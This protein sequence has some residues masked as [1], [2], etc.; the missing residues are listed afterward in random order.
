M[1]GQVPTM[2]RETQ[3]QGNGGADQALARAAVRMVPLSAYLQRLVWW[4]MLPLLAV[5]LYLGVDSV[6]ALRAANNRAA[7]QLASEIARDLEQFLQARMDALD[8]LAH[9]PSLDA[10]RQPGAFQRAAQPL[11]RSF[12]S[13][14]ILADAS[15]QMLMHTGQAHGSPLPR[16]PQPAGQSALQRALA[17]GRPAAG[18]SFTGPLTGLRMVGVAVPLAGAGPGV[19]PGEVLLISID[20]RQ[21]QRLIDGVPLPE[22]WSVRVVDSQQQALAERPAPGA[23]SPPARADTSQQ[24]TLGSTLAPWSITL[25]SS[26]QAQAAPVW[27]A[28]RVLGLAIVGATL[29]GWLAGGLASRRLARAVASLSGDSPEAA[30][31]EPIREIA[32]A[33]KRL[34]DAQRQR[35][36]SDAATRASEAVFRAVFLGLPDAAVLSDSA[37]RIQLVNPAFEAQFGMPAATVLGRSTDCLHA[38]EAGRA[39]IGQRL[40]DPGTQAGLDVCEMLYR[41]QDGSSFWAETSLVRLHNADGSLRGIFGLHRDISQRR[42]ARLGAQRERED[43]AQQVSA[44]TAELELAFRALEDTARFNRAVT[45]N[46][47]GRVTYWDSGLVCRFANQAQLAWRGLP[48]DQ[49]LGRHMAEL[50]DADS[51]A[52]ALPHAQAALGG[53]RQDFQHTRHLPTGDEVYQLIYVPDRVA[54]QPVQGFYVL[55]FD[56]TA[57]KRAEAELRSLNAALAQARD[58]AEAATRAKSAFLANMS[59]EIR[60]P[61]NAIIGLS[62]LLGRDTRDARQRERLGKIDTAARHLLQV[63]NDILDLS[64]I[65]A[66]RMALEDTAFAVDQLVARAFEMVSGPA[67]EAGLEL[68]VDTDHLPAWL[69]GDPTRLSQALINLLANAVKFTPKGWVRLRASVVAEDRQQLQVRFE[70]QDTGIGIAPALQATL[71]T[72]FEQGDS[73][74]TR[75]HGGTGLGLALT[76][77]LARLMGGEA[78][79][80]SQPGQGSSFW[81][82][83][84]L[85]RAEQAGER[86]AP[87]PLTGLR[88][89]LVD[90]LPET[91]A[92]LTDQLQ[93]LGLTVDAQPGSGAALQQAQAELAAGRAYDLVLVDWRMPAPDGLA[94]LKALRALL[95]PGMPPS[96]L[97]TAYNEPVVWQQA[98]AAAVDAV[99]VKPITPSALH[100]TLVQLLR[101]Q[102]TALAA[103]PA[104]PGEAEALVLQRHGGQRVLLAED[105]PVNCEVAEELLA[106]VGLAVETAADGAEAV[107][108]ALARRYDLVLMDMQMPVQDGLAAAR[109]IRRHTGT[110]LPIVAMTANAFAEDRAACLAAG[111]DDHLAKPVNPEQLYA[112][113]LRWLPLPAAADGVA[114]RAKAAPAA[115]MLAARLA[116]IPGLDTAAALANLGA[117]MPLYT[118][119]LQ[120][121]ADTY[122][123]GCAGLATGS[124]ASGWAAHCH[125]LR[126]A[127]SA[128]GALSVASLAAVLEQDLVHSVDPASLAPRLVPLQ[129]ELASLVQQLGAATRG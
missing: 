22:G 91:L 41:R 112:M 80:S 51:L 49:V 15:G 40:Q 97:M 75:R 53:A 26:A 67:A 35:A 90:D 116:A 122:R 33:Q 12:G 94:M 93:A 115:P 57:L 96:I 118:R 31:V 95:G 111:M 103:T 54:D 89:L 23:A 87:I 81:F 76:R 124:D 77:H 46:L 74:T 19:R 21:L 20:T 60:T 39:A 110:A 128:I 24:R 117:D 120:R 6:Q 58:E 52:L 17:S 32:A 113:L 4:S 43:L 10:P 68:I 66:G 7:A 56:I 34:A 61:M 45:D 121:F 18:D 69:R 9:S 108:M 42:A 59:H 109:A 85:G 126:G 84:W 107:A 100:D 3:M 73:A 119:L 62:H 37:R 36:Q 99:L 13:E 105:N 104:V 102:G 2:A 83:A 29:T 123:P 11:Q 38:D 55:G 129:A 101:R 5:A 125:S 14:V 48:A 79:V 64:K 50:L 78:G 114:S 1:I 98:R 106:R 63:I 8:A 30:P 86:A 70:V 127:C 92:V 16:L 72:P 25:T 71:F 47:P 88:A 28:A 27:H 44:R 65:E 82:T